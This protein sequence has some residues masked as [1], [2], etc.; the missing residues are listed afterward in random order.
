MMDATCSDLLA[1]VRAFRQRYPEV[2]YVDLI[3][4][5]FQGISTASVIRWTCWKRWR[6]AAR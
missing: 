2:R 3:S 1:E 4:W 5:I 6:P